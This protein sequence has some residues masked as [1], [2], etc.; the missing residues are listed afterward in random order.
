M[1]IEGWHISCLISKTPD[2]EVMLIFLGH[3]HLLDETV[4]LDMSQCFREDIGNHF[5]Y[6]N[7][8]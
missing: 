8:G 4:E 6:S 7:V 3:P 5:V 2:V 1:T